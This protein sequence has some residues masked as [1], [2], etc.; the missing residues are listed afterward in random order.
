M[1]ISCKNKLKKVFQTYT[2]NYNIDG[3]DFEGYEQ[4]SLQLSTGRDAIQFS[5]TR[6]MGCYG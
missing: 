5:L 1:E 3:S 2:F 6:M 4:H